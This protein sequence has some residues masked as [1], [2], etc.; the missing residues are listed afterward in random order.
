[1]V[2][3][4]YLDVKDEVHKE[5]GM[6]NYVRGLHGSIVCGVQHFK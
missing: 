4:L 2:L 3:I 6:L 5:L 1:M